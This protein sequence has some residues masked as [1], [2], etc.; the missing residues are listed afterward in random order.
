MT[1]AI[2]ESM[3]FVFN[4]ISLTHKAKKKLPREAAFFGLKKLIILESLI[5]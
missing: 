5:S 3:K 4:W 2:M 1:K